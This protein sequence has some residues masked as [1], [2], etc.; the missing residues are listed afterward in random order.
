EPRPLDAVDAR[1]PNLFGA[2]KAGLLEHVKVPR[3]G[4]PRAREARRDIA[5]GHRPA[6]EGDG[7]QDLTAR[8]VRERLEHGF[9]R[10]EPGLRVECQWSGS[11]LTSFMPSSSGPMGSHTAM[12][13]GV[14]CAMPDASSSFH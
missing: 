14:W 2:Q 10:L 4:R 13:S 12:T 6:A 9:E 8:R 1:P 7:E 5:G 3:R 11:R